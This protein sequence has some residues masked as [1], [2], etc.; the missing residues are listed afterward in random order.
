[1]DYADAV[2]AEVKDLFAAGVDV[3]Q[4]DEP[5][6]QARADEAGAYAIEA[7]NRALDG[8]GGTTA[9]HICFGYAM[10]HHGAGATGPKPKAYDFL[11]ALE[12]SAIDATS[13]EAAQPGLD[14]ATLAALPT[15]TI[16][17][18][19]LDPSI[20]HVETPGAVAGSPREAQHFV[21]A[22]RRWN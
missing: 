13:V 15:K 19:A 1:M 6:L 11:A 3:V 17:Y 21:R 22:T 2:N 14:P 4:L 8:V 10:V 18:G 5:Y 9:L 20:P 12:A 16:L 7:I